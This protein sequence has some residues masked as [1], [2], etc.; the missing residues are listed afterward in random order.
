MKIKGMKGLHQICKSRAA[1]LSLP[2][3]TSVG[4]DVQLILKVDPTTTKAQ[5]R[6]VIQELDS[7]VSFHGL[8][9]EAKIELHKDLD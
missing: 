1:G 4:E 2:D 7:T 9:T 5:L 3:E 8:F 6:N